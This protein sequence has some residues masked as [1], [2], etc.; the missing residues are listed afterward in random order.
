MDILD[1]RK[2]DFSEIDRF[3]I[4]QAADAKS[5]GKPI[6]HD[7]VT[8]SPRACQYGTLCRAHNNFRTR[9]IGWRKKNRADHHP[10]PYLDT[11]MKT[12]HVRGICGACGEYEIAEVHG[13]WRSGGHGSKV[14][15]AF[16]GQ[17]QRFR[18]HR[19]PVD[20][21]SPGRRVMAHDGG[22]RGGT[23]RVK[24]DRCR[25]SQGW[26][27]AYSDMPE[28]DGKEQWEDSPNQ[29]CSCWFALAVVDLPQVA[30]PCTF[31]TDVVLSLE[32]RL[33]YFVWF[34]SFFSLLT[35]AV[36]LPPIVTRYACALAAT[37]S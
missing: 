5:R 13:I 25:E 3:R 17:P 37:R 19:R 11:L 27:M 29:A 32:L 16:P 24:M 33:F 23:F 1:R 6:L 7:C 18:Y 28:C 9:C 2:H 4:Q 30:R 34:S 26:T 21:C 36:A 22:T 12:D 8:W 14:D 10:N 15:E 31:R 20:N 35:K